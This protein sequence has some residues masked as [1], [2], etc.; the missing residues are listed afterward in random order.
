MPDPSQLNVGDHVRF[1][2]LPVEWSRPGHH[3]DAE[4]VAFM[5]AL[6]DRRRPCRVARIVDG[7][8]CIDAR[9]RDSSGDLEHH[10]WTITESTGW[11]L[12]PSSPSD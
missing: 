11:Q 5:T 6:I 10:S 7:F 12:H 2:S 8:P 9:L 1:V 3:V 4:S